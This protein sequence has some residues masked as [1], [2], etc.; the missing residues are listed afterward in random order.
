[1]LIDRDGNV[2]ISDFGLISITGTQLPGSSFTSHMGGSVRWMAP[3][4]FDP[5]AGQTVTRAT[6]VYAFGMTILEVD[7]ESLDTTSSDHYL[8]DLYPA[9]SFRR[10]PN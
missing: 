10:P 5:E 1:M 8:A 9:P 7:S 4:L 6:N 3:E 2:R